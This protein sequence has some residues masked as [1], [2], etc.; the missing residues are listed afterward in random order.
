MQ[1][2]KRREDP[3]RERRKRLALWSAL[4]IGAAIAGLYAITA[5]GG[6]GGSAGGSDDY[7]YAVGQ[8]GPG[9]DA[10][11]LE[12]ASTAGGIF[13][14]A[15]YR[16]K[17]QV[18]LYFQEG[19]TCQPCWD[20]MRAIEQRLGKFRALGIEEIVSVT[21]DP[22]D[23]IEQKMKDE[24][25]QMPVLADV[26]AQFSSAWSANRYQMMHMGE[27]NGHSFILV[28]KDGKIVW[29]GD[30]GGEPKYTMFLPVD[31]LLRDLRQG[32]EQAT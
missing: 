20:Q 31:V 21:T 8:P 27:R 10:L 29:R 15:D 19:L 7:P 26:S 11:P 4:A 6:G 5:G 3:A 18:L 25:I 2:P 23:L 9:D 32:I 28:G 17:E 13:D 22:I 30:Y 14:L 16:G 24:G 12:L 1:A